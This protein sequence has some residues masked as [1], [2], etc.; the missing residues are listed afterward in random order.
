MKISPAWGYYRLCGV[1]RQ[2]SYQ[3]HKFTAKCTRYE[4]HGEKE[5]GERHFDG[6][7]KWGWY[8]DEQ[9]SDRVQ[10]TDGDTEVQQ[11]P[12]AVGSAEESA[13]GD[14]DRGGEDA[15]GEM[16]MI[17][18][19]FVMAAHESHYWS[20]YGYGTLTAAEA[21]ERPQ[22]TVKFCP[23]FKRDREYLPVTDR[24]PDDPRPICKEC[25]T[26]VCHGCWD[27]RRQ[28]ANRHPNCAGMQVCRKCG[29]REGEFLATRHLKY[30]THR[31]DA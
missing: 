12:L 25:A 19:C 29:S 30:N 24:H 18:A 3:G 23:G 31:E 10:L 15:Q 28:R 22:D 2:T 14:A 20:V 5:N 21:S 11:V 17:Q 27:Y 6:F 8:A 1:L 13:A 9:D 4:G 26:W 16:R 7:R